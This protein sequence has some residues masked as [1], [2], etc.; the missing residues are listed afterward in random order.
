MVQVHQSLSVLDLAR[1][2]S[3]G[4]STLVTDNPDT[5]GDEVAYW[6]ETDGKEGRKSHADEVDSMCT[7]TFVMRGIRP[8]LGSG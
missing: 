7:S 6:L 2:R 8:T 3:L 1:A 4:S 5:F